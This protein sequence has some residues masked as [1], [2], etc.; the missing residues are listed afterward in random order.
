[1]RYFAL[2][3]CTNPK[4][5]LGIELSSNNPTIEDLRETAEILST[6]IEKG[7]CLSPH[8]R[9][10]LLQDIIV[11]AHFSGEIVVDLIKSLTLW[12]RSYDSYVDDNNVLVLKRIS[13][14]FPHLPYFDILNNNTIGHEDQFL[15][16]QNS[17]GLCWN[18]NSKHPFGWL[19]K[20]P[21]LVDSIKSKLI[22]ET[23]YIRPL[24]DPASPMA[25]ICWLFS[26]DT[27]GTMKVQGRFDDELKNIG[28]EYLY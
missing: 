18:E 13:H 16:Y 27:K 10:E 9:I 7:H 14:I 25:V 1:M 26:P 21:L 28:I 4:S 19:S 3:V 24:P 17:R 6:L 22:E 15:N 23:D 2:S 12:T 11:A 8:K 5:K 20:L